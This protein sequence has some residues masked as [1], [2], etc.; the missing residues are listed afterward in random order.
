MSN[1]SMSCA[2]SQC[3]VESLSSNC[4]TKMDNFFDLIWS[5]NGDSKSFIEGRIRN[6][7]SR[8]VSQ[9]PIDDMT[10]RSNLFV[11]PQP[12]SSLEECLDAFKASEFIYDA[13]PRIFGN[14]HQTRSNFKLG[15]FISWIMY[16]SENLFH[17]DEIL[18]LI[19]SSKL[20]IPDMVVELWGKGEGQSSVSGITYGKELLLLMKQSL[21]PANVIVNENNNG[22]NPH[23]GIPYCLYS[24]SDEEGVDL[25]Y[26]TKFCQSMQPIINDEGLCY[27]FN[28]EYFLISY[29][30]MN[31]RLETGMSKD[32][33]SKSHNTHHGRTQSN[34]YKVIVAK[35]GDAGGKVQYIVKPDFYGETN[36]FLSGIHF[37]QTTPGFRSWNAKNEFCYFPDGKKLSHFRVYAQENC[38]I[39]CKIRRVVMECDCSPWFYSNSTLPLCDSR[40]M[41][42]FE[43][44]VSGYKDDI[45]DRSLC[46]CKND[47]EMVHSIFSMST[48]KYVDR[49]LRE[50]RFWYNE[51]NGQGFLSD[52]LMDPKGIFNSSLTMSLSSLKHNLSSNRE[53][54][55]FR[56]KNDIA[57]MNFYYVT[58]IITYVVFLELKV[59]I[60]DQI[61]AIGGQLGLF[62]GFSLISGFEVIYWIFSLLLEFIIAQN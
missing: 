31:P 34:G 62:T 22:M 50:P 49:K 26:E 29:L 53:L 17:K 39:E 61:S 55:Q 27:S 8:I 19:I 6:I 60:F 25:G 41:R 37:V 11:L 43:D 20:F 16:H 18:E 24:R 48:H 35:R 5:A 30:V 58:P 15:T 23:P 12:P 14:L 7:S 32:L 4:T 33:E 10:K 47:C 44:G 51:E 45:P 46:D 21:S 40:G 57:I 1:E 3:K 13:I 54:A 2:Y 59:S 42:C 28:N 36:F 56:F 38:L 9:M 52:Y